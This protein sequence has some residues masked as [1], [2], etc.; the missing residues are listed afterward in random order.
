MHRDH[1]PDHHAE[2][3]DRRRRRRERRHAETRDDI[4]AAAREVL[5]ERGAAELS[6]REIARRARYSPGAL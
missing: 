3:A 2:A 4:R 6:L 1:F 5:L